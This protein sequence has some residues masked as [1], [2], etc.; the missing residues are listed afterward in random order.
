MTLQKTVKQFFFGQGIDTKPSAESTPTG[1]LQLLQNARLDRDNII[2]KKYGS[3]THSGG[4][5]PFNKL[6]SI[7]NDLIGIVGLAGPNLTSSPEAGYRYSQTTDSWFTLDRAGT[8]ILSSRSIGDSQYN[9]NTSITRTD[10]AVGAGFSCTAAELLGVSGFSV[11]ISVALTDLATNTIVF[12][13]R[14]TT[15]NA[16]CPRVLFVDGVFLILFATGGLVAAYELTTAGV[17]RV[18]TNSAAG[19]LFTNTNLI[20]FYDAITDGT[21]IHIIYRNNGGSSTLTILTYDPVTTH[22]FSTTTSITIG[23]TPDLHISLFYSGSRVCYLMCK[24]STVIGASYAASNLSGITSVITLASSGAASAYGSSL[25][26]S[27]GNL[28]LLSNNGGGVPNNSVLALYWDTAAGTGGNAYNM[29]ISYLLASR[30]FTYNNK[31]Y[32][33]VYLAGDPLQNSI[34]LLSF[35]GGTPILAYFMGRIFYGDANPPLR[36]SQTNPL[37]AGFDSQPNMLPNVVLSSTGIFSSVFPIIDATHSSSD[38]TLSIR[39]IDTDF[40][41]PVRYQSVEIAKTLLMSGSN[42]LDYDGNSLVEDA[43]V[44]SPIRVTL[45]PGNGGSLTS[46]GTYQYV[47]VYEWLDGKGQLHRSAPSVPQTITL[48]GTNNNVTVGF[49]GALPT[50]KNNISVRIFR[51]Q[52]LGSTFNSVTSQIALTIGSFTMV[53]TGTFTYL[54]TAADTAIAPNELLYTTGNVFPNDMLEPVRGMTVWDQRVWAITDSGIYYSK[55]VSDGSPVEFSLFLNVPIES[56]GGDVTGIAALV[57]KLL[58]FKRGKIYF[59][60]GT[61]PDNA[62]G[63]SSYTQPQ[64]VEATTGCLSHQAIIELGAAVFFQSRNQYYSINSGLQI[65]PVGEELDFFFNE[66][67]VV[68]DIQILDSDNEIRIQTASYVFVYNTHTEQWGVSPTHG[69][70]SITMWNDKLARIDSTGAVYLEDKTTWKDGSSFVELRASTGWI[71]LNQIE[72]YQRVWRAYLLARYKTDHTIN[73]NVYYDYVPKVIDTYSYNAISSNLASFSDTN[74]FTANPYAGAGNAYMI[75]MHLKHQKCTA[76]KFEFYDSNQVGT[77]Q[78]LDLLGLAL[79]LGIENT[80][81]KTL[82]AAQSI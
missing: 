47:L 1:K 12:Q 78:S 38:T 43:F 81:T 34:I 8:A 59:I 18:T 80:G 16:T 14:I 30:P 19:S 26:T 54:D 79:E 17:F 49:S 21:N 66:N 45:T 9:I 6:K 31:D 11:G 37:P 69:G 55:K 40:I 5:G 44:S 33:F 4:L 48:S 10:I 57:D 51:T 52:N 29:T 25:V 63:G 24:T 61:G 13:T 74:I 76:I 58:I 71:Q 20:N 60:S 41:N 32:C 70:P 27:V 42:I 36:L 39:R 3:G 53:P 82:P 77:G 64:L 22:A 72:G 2:Q 56:A 28:V 23:Q 75:R 67:T 68:T 35:T 50:N 73:V 65:T 62:G 46:P 15:S 7:N